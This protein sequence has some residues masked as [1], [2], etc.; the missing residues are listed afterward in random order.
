MTSIT[1]AHSL[2]LCNDAVSDLTSHTNNPATV[3][4]NPEPKIS[5]PPSCEGD[6]LFEPGDGDIQINVNGTRF[7]THK[8]LIKRFRGLKQLLDAHPLE[9]RIQR[10]NISAEHFNEMF[11]MLYAS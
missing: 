5:T 4:P 9:I 8:Y 2:P 10:E 3:E 7:E 11:K 1:G 6:P